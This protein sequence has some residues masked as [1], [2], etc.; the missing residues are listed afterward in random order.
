MHI[1]L[2]CTLFVNAFLFLFF[3]RDKVTDVESDPMTFRTIVLNAVHVS[4]ISPV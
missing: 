1:T 4:S 3:L 2:I